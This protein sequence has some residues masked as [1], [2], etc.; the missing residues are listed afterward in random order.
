MSTEQENSQTSHLKTKII[1]LGSVSFLAL[2]N[3]LS[4]FLYK[5]NFPY[6]VDYTDI[7]V[8]VSTVLTAILEK[9]EKEPE[10]K[11]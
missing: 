11:N 6:S 3:F 10:I 9:Y 2:Q 5:L 1:I 7:F 8:P 4:V